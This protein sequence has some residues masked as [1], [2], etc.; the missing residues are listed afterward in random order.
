MSRIAKFW[1]VTA[2]RPEST[3]DDVVFE[4]TPASFIVQVK[5]GLGIDDQPR[6][7]ETRDEAVA[8]AERRLAAFKTY[9]RVLDGRG[10][11]EQ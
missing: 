6:F 5:G 11:D 2:P 4:A 7:Y 8:E 10:G 3:L 1:V 9:R